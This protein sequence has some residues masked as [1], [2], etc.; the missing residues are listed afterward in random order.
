MNSANPSSILQ[1]PEESIENQTE[2]SLKYLNKESQGVT[3]NI[4]NQMIPN[5]SMSSNN[6]QVNS[7]AVQS[8]YKED[9]LDENNK[10]INNS[11]RG[12]Y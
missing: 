2:D 9:K 12:S 8:S 1:K 11:N 10:S 5:N 3:N 4:E 7:H 6:L